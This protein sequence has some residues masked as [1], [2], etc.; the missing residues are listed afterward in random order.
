[1]NT[2]IPSWGLYQ[3]QTHDSVDSVV[4]VFINMK[5][6]QQL[7]WEAQPGNVFLTGPEAK[8]M[9]CPW[10]SLSEKLLVGSWVGQA[11]SLSG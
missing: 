10:L 9:D 4:P 6:D 7:T 3:S 2:G 8:F 1:M 5:S 11:V